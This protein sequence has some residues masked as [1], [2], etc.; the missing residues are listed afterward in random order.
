[1]KF[2]AK[3][4]RELVEQ[5]FEKAWVNSDEVL[6]LK[7]PNNIYPRYGYAVGEEHPIF[8]TINELRKAYISLGFKEVVN[9]LIVEDTHVKRQFGKEALAVLDRCF[10]LA[11]LPRPD[12]GMSSEKVEKISKIIGRKLKAKEIADLQGILHLFKKGKIDG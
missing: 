10:Y 8:K 1:M 3:K 6:S 7:S 5:D 4:Y 11:S 12:V 9:P 2:N